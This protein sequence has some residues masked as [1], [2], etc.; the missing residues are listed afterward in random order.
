MEMS[1]IGLVVFAV[2]LTLGCA[3][4]ARTIGS[5]V[6]QP[7]SQSYAITISANTVNDLPPCASSLYGTTALVQSPISIYTC[8]A[9]IPKPAWLPV[10]CTTLLAG[11][12]AYASMSQTLVACVSGKWTQV[13]LPQGPAG[14]QGP[15]GVMGTT[16]MTGPSGAVGAMGLTGMTGAT[17]AT[18]LQS[19]IKV[20][21]EP[22]GP[23]CAT[24]GERIDTG[25]DANGDG[26]LGVS[27]IQ[28][29]VYVCN[30]ATGPAGP[31]GP[32]G[33]NA[34]STLVSSAAEPP[35][36]NCATGGIK[37]SFGPDSDGSGALDPGEVKSVSY[38]CNGAQGP[39]GDAGVAGAT[40]LVVSTPELAGSHCAA[41][42]VKLTAGPDTNGNGMLDSDEVTST[43]YVCNG[44]S[45]GAPAAPIASFTDSTCDPSAVP[46]TT[47]G[48][49]VDS[50]MGDD[51]LGTGDAD[52]P[53][54]TL[55]AAVGLSAALSHP[56]VYLTEGMYSGVTLPAGSA[57]FIEGGWLRTSDGWH[58]DCASTMVAAA[59]V[60]SGPVVSQATSGGLRWV[61]VAAGGAA[62]N[63]A[64]RV[65]SG[66]MTVWQSVLNAGAGKDGVPGSS[67]Y[68]AAVA[69]PF[70]SCGDGSSGTRGVDGAPSHGGTFL[71]D[72]TFVPGN[73]GTGS[74]STP[75]MNGYEASPTWCY[76][77]T[78]YVYTY[79]CNCFFGCDTC[80]E[81]STSQGNA[82]SVTGN[83]GQGGPAGS[84]GAPGGG[85]GASVALS[86]GS[87]AL[88]NVVGSS[89]TSA[90]GGRGAVAGVGG[91]GSSGG[92]GYTNSASCSNCGT[93]CATAYYAVTSTGGPGGFGPPGAN[94]GSGAGGPSYAIVEV[95]AAALTMDAATVL[96]FGAGGTA[97]AGASS[98]ASGSIAALP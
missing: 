11:A 51:T 18:G 74:A 53:V 50:A 76:P 2:A 25:I 40:S 29:T 63:I 26:V 15:Q 80:S 33:A 68:A 49:F 10:P 77:E 5:N 6:A 65:A 1:K 20:T 28:Q 37:L 59:T 79:S 27:E 71:S 90:N 17:G 19:L 69:P 45:G 3:K 62:S 67:G 89:L 14:A 41:G 73:G 8:Q 70:G 58:R 60:L 92:P 34:I 98:G 91:G 88:V 47:K 35:G 52:A 38:V 30:G 57:V 36:P 97:I 86:V 55:A 93:N 32:A 44:Q 96:A 78:C 9:G 94:G 75:G 87:T 12:V 83:C 24:G 13:P 16:G 56:N 48:V 23:N 7:T 85:G 39:A 22:A 64:V 72:G 42:G 66:K 31:Q 81:C 54:K 46:D 82:F 61:T 95:G 21:P 43:S 4:Q 84:P